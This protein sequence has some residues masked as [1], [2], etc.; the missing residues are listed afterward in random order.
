MPEL[1]FHD[2]D[3]PEGEGPR[4]IIDYTQGDFFIHMHVNPDN[5]LQHFRLR[6]PE[7]GGGRPENEKLW[8]ALTTLFIRGEPPAKDHNRPKGRRP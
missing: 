1:I 3:S 7:I 4:L 8:Q 5:P 2:D 6:M